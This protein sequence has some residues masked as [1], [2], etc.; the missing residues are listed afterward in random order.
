MTV[1]RGSGDRLAETVEVLRMARLLGTDPETLAKLGT[2]SLA[3]MRQIYGQH[4]SERMLDDAL[5]PF[6]SWRDEYRR[7]FGEEGI[8]LSYGEAVEIYG[9]VV[10]LL[11]EPDPESPD[12]RQRCELNAILNAI[13]NPCFETGNFYFAM[14]AVRAII[15]GFENDGNSKTLRVWHHGETEPRE[16]SSWDRYILYRALEFFVGE[17]R[18]NPA[19]YTVERPDFERAQAIL[20]KRTVNRPAG[21][22][23]PFLSAL[24]LSWIGQFLDAL[25]GCGMPVTSSKPRASLA[26]AMAEAT[27]IPE[28]AICDSWRDT[29]TV[30]L[31]PDRRPRR[32]RCARCG[33]P[34][35]DDARRDGAEGDLVCLACAPLN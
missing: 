2:P 11:S 10:P 35:G 33:E 19:Q 32:R 3:H 28:T 15:E 9:F 1:R 13:T 8:E 16:V 4:V 21:R 6:Y 34:A 20:G 30:V 17:I 22:H 7:R 24:R 27:G 14:V 26:A 12:Y 5:P 29:D 23:N 31:R 18:K 25:Q